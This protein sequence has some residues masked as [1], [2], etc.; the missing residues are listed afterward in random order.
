MR[1]LLILVMLYSSAALADTT[2]YQAFDQQGYPSFSDKPQA[3]AEKQKTLT[4]KDDITPEQAAL[5]DQR[6][7]D[8]MERDQ[9]RSSRLKTEREQ[10]Q[11]AKEERPKLPEVPVYETRQNTISTG[12]TYTYGD[13]PVRY[14]YYNRG[15]RTQE[16]SHNIPLRATGNKSARQGTGIT[17]HRIHR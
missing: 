16:I 10:A 5:A 7:Q 13:I 2:V 17:S 12:T 8:L 3:N 15:A 14:D 11:L 9:E 6:Y 4:I 1:T